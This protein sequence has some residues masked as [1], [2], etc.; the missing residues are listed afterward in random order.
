MSRRNVLLATLGF[1][2]IFAAVLFGM[3]LKQEPTKTVPEQQWDSMSI[4]NWRMQTSPEAK[5][6]YRSNPL[7]LYES[8]DSL[9]PNA[10][11]YFK[12]STQHLHRVK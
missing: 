3:A 5:A 4:A 11:F 1:S 8:T 9:G 10:I 2:L 6:W 7:W 12:D